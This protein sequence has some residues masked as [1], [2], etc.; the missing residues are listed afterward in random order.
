[1]REWL[2]RLVDMFRR[3]RLDAELAEELRHHRALATRDGERTT[4]DLRAREA[5]RDQWSW[6]WLDQLQQD[7]RF[8][9][10]G[11]RRNPG[12][13]AAVVITLGL[14]IGANAVMFGVLDR[15]MFRPFP[16]LRDPKTVHKVYIESQGRNGPIF[17]TGYEYTRYLDLQRWTTSFSQVAAISAGATAIGTRQ[18]TRV[19]RVARVS[20]T[21]FDFFVVRPAL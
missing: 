16:Y 20:G 15:I 14:G 9:L 1:M 10:R 12:F 2:M 21:F 13:A 8:A 7:L 18:D 5:S 19:R 4:S 6:P 17:H 3:D 11:L